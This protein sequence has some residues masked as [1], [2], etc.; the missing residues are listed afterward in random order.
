MLHRI[1]CKYLRKNTIMKT[2]EVFFLTAIALSFIP[3][4][5]LAAATADTTPSFESS[6][7]FD[8]LLQ[9]LTALISVI[10]II[11]VLSIV[12]RKFNMVPG[13]NSGIIKIVSGLALNN[14][15]RLLLVQVGDEQ[16][17]LSV[18]PGNI[19]KLHKLAKPVLKSEEQQVS[20]DNKKNFSTLLNTLSK[21][22]KS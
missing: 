9:V 21:R 13:A 1:I 15:D 20:T 5:A 16:V 22:Q 19:S 8:G 3:Y 17:L 18:S 7:N 6:M 14:K 11:F 4:S 12:L 10:V 2:G